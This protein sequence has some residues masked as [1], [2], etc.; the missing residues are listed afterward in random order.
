LCFVVFVVAAFIHWIQWNG[1][2]GPIISSLNA[3]ATLGFAFS[4]GMLGFLVAGFAIFATI[5]KPDLFVRL[6][7]ISYPDSALTALKYVFFSFVNVFVHYLSFLTLCVAVNVSF[8]A[9]WPGSSLG[10]ALAE[11]APELFGI[12]AHVL[13]VWL[14]T[15]LIVLLVKLK[16]FIWNVYQAVLLS[17]AHQAEKQEQ[18]MKRTICEEPEGGQ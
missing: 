14:A 1:S 4:S 5:S 8:W 15:W 12:V 3:W 11:V 7:Q 17:I 13:L 9:E 18:A 10:R 2:P 16:S 6:A